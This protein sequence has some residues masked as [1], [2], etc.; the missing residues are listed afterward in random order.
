MSEADKQLVRRHFEEIFNCKNLD[1]LRCD[2]GR[3]YTEH[4]LA[5]F[6]QRAPGSVNGPEHMRA[7]AQWLLEQFP[8]LP[9]MIQLGVIQPPGRPPSQRPGFERS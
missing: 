2:R 1:A 6:G 8:D 4:A 7:V 9:T 3:G 5:P